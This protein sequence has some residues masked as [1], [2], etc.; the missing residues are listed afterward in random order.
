MKKTYLLAGT[1]ILLWSTVATVTKLL[2][3]SMDKYQ[4]LCVS[5]LF[6]ALALFAVNLFTGRLKQLRD[7]RLMDYVKTIGPSLLGN[8]L[9]YV[10]YYGGTA[11]MPASQAFIVNYLWPIMSVVFACILLKERLTGRKIAAFAVSFLGVFTVAGGD[12]LQ[13]DG[14]ILLGMGMC[15][16]GAV[17]YGAFTALIKKWDYDRSLGMM[18]GFFASFVLSLAVTLVNGTR[19][20]I[21]P[22]ALAGFGWNGV[23]CMALASTSWALALREGNTAKVS[24]L[25]YITPFLSLVWV[26]VF[27]KEMP[28]PWSVGGLLLI[29][30]GIFIQLKDGKAK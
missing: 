10:F 22:A 26:A 8:F 9:Y 7:F 3:G 15:A 27:L 11:R 16:A 19:W 5:A 24:N 29:V 6:A 18:L 25:A 13:F 28:T 30:L 21:S 23:C 2:L 20:D 4:I 14:N 17:C 12:L 1:A